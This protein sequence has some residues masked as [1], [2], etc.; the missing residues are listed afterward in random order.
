[1]IAIIGATGKV[2]SQTTEHLLKAGKNVLLIARKEDELRPYQNRGAEIAVGSAS[3][4]HFL[5][6]ALKGA[7]IVL[8]MIPADLNSPDIKSHQDK[9]GEATIAAIKSAGIKHVVNL[10]SVGGHTEENTGIVAGLARQEIRLNALEGVNVLHL[11]PTSFM[12]NYF[13]NIPMIR[14]NGIL[15]SVLQPDVT[16]PLISCRDIAWVIAQ[17]LMEPDFSGKSVRALLGPRDYTMLEVSKIL[18]E[19]IGKPDLQY[20]QFSPEDMKAGMMQ[21]GVSASVAEAFNGLYE[22]INHGVFAVEKRDSSSTTPT[23]LEEFARIFAQ[24]YHQKES[25]HA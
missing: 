1:M 17:E 23:T 21:F 19:A 4:T 12:E 24:V 5:S 8:T 13:S 18:G 3:D 22:G 11:R 15:G 6:E 20:V 10:S 2:G 14:N 7:D 9:I 25:V 16:F